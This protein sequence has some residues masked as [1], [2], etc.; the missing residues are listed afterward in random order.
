MSFK[1]IEHAFGRYLTVNVRQCDHN[2]HS[3][4]GDVFRNQMDTLRGIEDDDKRMG[5]V[6]TQYSHWRTASNQLVLKSCSSFI[7]AV[8]ELRC[9]DVS[10]DLLMFDRTYWMEAYT[11]HIFAAVDSFDGEVV[12]DVIN[13]LGSLQRIVML[14]G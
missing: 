11:F 2:D 9:E 12:E 13:H 4:F 3:T 6:K 10:N 14:T 5:S 1:V 7:L 8:V